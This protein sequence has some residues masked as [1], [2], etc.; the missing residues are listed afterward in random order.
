MEVA[1][2]VSPME[3][4]PI[5]DCQLQGIFASADAGAEPVAGSAYGK[6][7]GNVVFNF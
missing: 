2:P 3:A 7:D 5:A 6:A 4:P 1:M